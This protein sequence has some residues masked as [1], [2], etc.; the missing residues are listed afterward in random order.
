[1]SLSPITDIR[2]KL[3][4]SRQETL[5]LLKQIDEDSALYRVQPDA[6]NIKEHVIHLIA[7]EEAIVQ[8]ADCILQEESPRSALCDER[9]F[10]QDAWNIQAVAE[11]ATYTWP[12]TVQQLEQ[13]HQSLLALIDTIPEEA[14]KRVGSHPVWGDPVTLASILRHPYRH[15]RDHRNEIAALYRLKRLQSQL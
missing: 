8:F 9:D 12:E 10:N 4:Q 5:Q 14:L 11:R 2:Q 6:W 1:M 3:R 13:T 7:V 15:E